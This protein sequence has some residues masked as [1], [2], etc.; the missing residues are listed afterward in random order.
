MGQRPHDN[1]ARIKWKVRDSSVV[2]EGKES[3]VVVFE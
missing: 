1:F 2:E 3:F